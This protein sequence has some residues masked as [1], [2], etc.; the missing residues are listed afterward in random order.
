MLVSLA[1]FTESS[2]RPAAE[3]LIPTANNSELVDDGSAQTLTQEQIAELKKEASPEQLIQLI[4][5]SSTTFAG[6]TEFSQEKYLKRKKKKYSNLVRAVRP[7][8]KQITETYL[9]RSL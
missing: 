5:K 1:S 8:A 7:T 4:A 2:L 9:V 6:K 3:A